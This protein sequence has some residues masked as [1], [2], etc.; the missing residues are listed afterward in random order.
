LSIYLAIFGKP[1][2]LGLLNLEEPVPPQ[3]SWIVAE[4]MRG[5]ELAL[6]GGIL[7]EEQEERYRKSC[8]ED[9]S[10]GQVKG[11]EPA[12]QEITFLRQ[13]HQEDL[14]EGKLEREEENAVLL[15]A[16]E[17]LRTHGLP[18]KLVDVEYLLDRKKL[19]FYFT[20]EQRV[21]FRSFVRDLAKE[22]KTRIELRQIG[23]RDEAKA[24]KGI[25]PCG[26]RCCCSYWL[27]RF[28]PI[29]IKM[30]KE[31]NL[32]LNPTKI[33]GICGRLMCCMSY[34]H[35]MYGSLW[36]GLPNPGS[37]IRTD[38]G[39]FLLEGVELSSESVRIRTPEG[40]EILVRTSDFPRFR[41]TV[42][43]GRPWEEDTQKDAL[44]FNDEPIRPARR[45][46]PAKKE[47][48]SPEKKAQAQE[49][50][51]PAEKPDIKETQGEEKKAEVQAGE[52]LPPKKKKRRKRKHPQG[53]KTQAGQPETSN[54]EKE[55]AGTEGKPEEPK[56]NQESGGKKR[57]RPRRRRPQKKNEGGAQSSP[58][59]GQNKNASSEV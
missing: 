35:H 21:D 49:K 45:R 42:T 15:K 37:K 18:M 50:K 34:E 36:K 8:N 33:S 30:V 46:G 40:K 57:P 54:R 55:E 59:N 51:K 27:H 26:Q 3:G 5:L 56:K 2:Y 20:S 16:R 19:F 48:V 23:V 10:D 28:T 12:L 14:A 47:E 13:A 39:T 24:V 43:E 11:G 31:Q 4:T 41:E 1:R 17:L 38:N 22:F 52:N 6:L 44:Q 25:A 58:A 32:A 7:S 53:E 9:T 29:C